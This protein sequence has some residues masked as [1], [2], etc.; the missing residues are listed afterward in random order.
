MS[1]L[2]YKIFKECTSYNHMVNIQNYLVAN[3]CHHTLLLLEHKPCYTVGRR[4]GPQNCKN[5]EERL[6]KLGAEFI[7]SKRGGEI[8]FHGPGQLV[9]Y[10]IMNL[11]GLEEHYGVR[12][13]IDCI[14]DILIETCLDFNVKTMVTKDTGVWVNDQKKIAAIGIQVQRHITSHGFAL[15]CNTDLNWFDQIVPCGLKG[16][17][18]TSLSAET[19]RVVTVEHAIP[20]LLERMSRKLKLEAVELK[21]VDSDLDAKLTQM[22]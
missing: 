18:A 12:K 1:M 11:K 6:S 2:R 7:Y 15:N 4:L 9:G 8:T 10:P 19:H 16:K 3:Q 21:D 20:K 13:Y 22:L 14:Q 17:T 5:E